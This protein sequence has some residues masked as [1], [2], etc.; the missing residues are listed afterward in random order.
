MG[1]EFS[2]SINGAGL[3][4]IT[5]GP[6]GNLC[7]PNKPATRSGGLPARVVTEFSTGSSPL[8]ITAGPDANLWFTEP[9]AHRIGRI[10]P[11]GVVS[12]FNA[13]GAAWGIT[14]GPD[15]NLWFTEYGPPSTGGTFKD[16]PQAHRISWAWE[17]Q[18]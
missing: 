7:S 3:G 15:G 8:L 10:T 17:L 4:G 2:D 11:L 1:T 14:A 5:A 16:D 12:Y 6:D 13:G 9:H 18:L